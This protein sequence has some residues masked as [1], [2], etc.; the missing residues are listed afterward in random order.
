MSDYE[1]ESGAV[2]QL[3]HQLVPEELP[4]FLGQLEEARVIA[5]T[6]LISP[7]PAQSQADELL[8]VTEA[9]HRLGVS[10]NYLYRHHGQFAFT[11]RLGKR[12]LFSGNG[13]EQY[14][15]RE[16]ALTPRRHLATV[17]PLR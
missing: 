2:L 9:A 12:L 1:Q 8:D 15:R 10:T 11:R 3:A 4:H 17:T 16:S 13:I 7:K 14:I 6:R 5:L